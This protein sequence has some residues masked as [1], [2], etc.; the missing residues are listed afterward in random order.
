MPHTIQSRHDCFTRG[1]NPDIDHVVQKDL[2]EPVS[3]E[4]KA[5]RVSQLA[6]ALTCHCK[7]PGVKANP[8][9]KQGAS[10]AHKIEA[11]GVH[12]VAVSRGTSYSSRRQLSVSQHSAVVSSVE[13][14]TS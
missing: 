10:T 5:S 4:S 3:F 9:R 13:G 6:R 12:Q 11:Q 7:V 1:A 2:F 8:S 14:G